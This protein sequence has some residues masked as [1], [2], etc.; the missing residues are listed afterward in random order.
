MT[1][2]GDDG[3]KLK[4]QS[5]WRPA[6]RVV[7]VQLI[8]GEVKGRDLPLSVGNIA[9]HQNGKRGTADIN[10]RDQAHCRFSPSATLKGEKQEDFQS[11]GSA[12]LTAAI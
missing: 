10:T 2:S 7:I 5:W 3:A 4:S 1:A 6:D 9:L 8:S 12:F 11:F